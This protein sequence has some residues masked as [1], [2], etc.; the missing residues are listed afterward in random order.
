M[1]IYDPVFWIPTA[2]SAIAV[3]LFYLDMRGRV[4]TSETSSRSML[5]LINLMRQELTLFRSQIQA[6][7]MKS[8]DLAKQKALQGEQDRKW[9]ETFNTI[10]AL[11]GFAEIASLFGDKED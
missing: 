3:T 1:G 6:S 8:I 2:V 5:T 4:K 9:K 7:N 11:K 10:K